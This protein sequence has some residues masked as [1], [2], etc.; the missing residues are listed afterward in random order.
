MVETVEVGSPT[1]KRLAER[2]KVQMESASTAEERDP[3]DY[4]LGALHSLFRAT[5]L[6]YQHRGFPLGNKYW[7]EGPMPRVRLMTEG[8]IRVEGKWLAGFYFNSALARIAAAFERAVRHKAKRK[9]IGT[10]VQSV[11]GLLGALQLRHF[12]RGNLALVYGEVNP[13]KHEAAGL[14][15]G[16][17]VSLAD[18]IAAFGEMLDLLETP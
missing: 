11:W 12:E 1:L 14:A 16:R 4:L 6:G 3:L 18:A 9:K 7:A 8:K 17:R 13:L 5:Q 10:G 2:L 15:K